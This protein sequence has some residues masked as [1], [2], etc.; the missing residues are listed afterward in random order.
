MAGRGL[1]CGGMGN[2]A[3]VGLRAVAVSRHV[4]AVLGSG[5]GVVG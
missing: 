5:L 4:A 1:M 2:D 3:G